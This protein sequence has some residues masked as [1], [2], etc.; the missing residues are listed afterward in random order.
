[1]QESQRGRFANR[2]WS[3]SILF[4]V[5][6]RVVLGFWRIEA[7]PEQGARFTP[8]GHRSTRHGLHEREDDPYSGED[9]ED[10]EELASG[11]SWH[12]VAIS[13]RRERDGAE[14]EGVEQAPPLHVPVEGG[15]GGEGQH[16]ETEER[17]EVG[18]P[19][20]PSHGAGK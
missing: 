6:I 20:S 12:E 18:I 19:Q 17:P 15:P 13:D 4:L 5:V 11:G 9:V 14:V 16:D 2:S 10:G 8:L 7:V 1:M 3:P